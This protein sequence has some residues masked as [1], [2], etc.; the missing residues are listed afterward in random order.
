MRR[1]DGIAHKQAITVSFVGSEK[2]RRRHVC[3]AV[4]SRN[5]YHFS[6]SGRETEIS[7]RKLVKICPEKQKRKVDNNCKGTRAHTLLGVS[8]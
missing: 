1:K 7:P 3:L 5:N 6:L 8:I 2:M 4:L